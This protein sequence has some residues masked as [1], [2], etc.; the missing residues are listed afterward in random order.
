VVDVED[1]ASSE[2]RWP[3]ARHRATCRTLGVSRFPGVPGRPSSAL[4]GP[5]SAAA[6]C[7]LSLHPASRATVSQTLA[8]LD[9]AR[10]LAPPESLA[11]SRLAVPFCGRRR[12]PEVSLP[13]DDVPRSGPVCSRPS[14]STAV[15]TPGFLTP[16]PVSWL[17]SSS[18]VCCAPLPSLGCLLPSERSPRVRSRTP[19]R[20]RWLPCRSSRSDPGAARAV[21]SPRPS[22]TRATFGRRPWPDPAVARGSLSAPLLTPPCG[23]AP[24]ETSRSPWTSCAGP[25]SVRPFRRLRSFLPCASPF[26]ARGDRPPSLLEGR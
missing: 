5:S 7:L 4:V 25:T 15:P 10:G 12:L 8:D 1:R 9:H 2:G 18:R 3:A 23:G 6:W 14:G 24:R 19:R 20:G 21:L 26:A 22:P 11:S 13:F 17:R 16:S